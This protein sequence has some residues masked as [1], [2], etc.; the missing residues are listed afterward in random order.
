V[1]LRQ[2]QLLIQHDTN[3][4]VESLVKALADAGYEST[5]SAA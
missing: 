1:R 3:T 5:P 4:P 2:G